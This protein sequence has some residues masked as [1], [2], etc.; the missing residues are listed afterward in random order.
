MKKALI[1]LLVGIS[2]IAVIVLIVS[3]PFM[4]LWNWIV[5]GIFEGPKISLLQTIGL[6]TLL[7]MIGSFFRS[8]KGK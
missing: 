3:L 2:V 7:S 8:N 6:M 1:A 4:W 5:P